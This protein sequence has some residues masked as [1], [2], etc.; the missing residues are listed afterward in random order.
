MECLHTIKFLPRRE[1]FL[2]TLDM[3]ATPTY[4]CQSQARID[5]ISVSIVEEFTLRAR[6]FVSTWRQHRAL[7]RET[8]SPP[9]VQILRAAAMRCA[10]Y[11]LDDII[12]IS[13]SRQQSRSFVLKHSIQSVFQFIWGFYCSSK[14]KVKLISKWTQC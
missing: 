4:T 7:S 11:Y 6:R 12:L 2:I 5:S 1:D 13:S 3:Y 10:I 8:T 9:V 14:K